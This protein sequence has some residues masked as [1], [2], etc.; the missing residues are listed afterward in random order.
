MSPHF[1]LTFS[2]LF[3]S[4]TTPSTSFDFH[5][6]F[7]SYHTT[8]SPSLFIEFVV[9]T[10]KPTTLDFAGTHDFAKLESVL[11]PSTSPPIVPLPTHPLPTRRS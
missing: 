9:D 8:N 1:T 3:P 10:S 4:I 11:P 2:H 6:P 5:L 7:T